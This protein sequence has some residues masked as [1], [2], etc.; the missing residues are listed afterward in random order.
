MRLTLAFAGVL[1]VMLTALGAYLVLRLRADLTADV[2]RSLSAR[3]GQVAAAYQT[4]RNPGEFA[5]ISASALA[6]LPS[7][8][9]AAQLL[10]T[11]GDILDTSDDPIATHHLLGAGDLR[12]VLAHG[13]LRSTVRVGMP[14]RLLA[15]PVTV[16]GQ[17][18]VLVLATSLAGIE[19]ATHR[20][21]VLLLTGGPLALLLASGTGWWLA[22]AALHPVA[23]MTAKARRITVDRLDERVAP[24]K[25]DDEL[26]RL[27]DTFNAM[28]DRLQEGVQIQHRLVADASHEL[29]TPLAVMRAELDVALTADGLPPDAVEVVSST[30]EEVD[31]MARLVGNLLALARIDQGRLDL[32]P[33]PV[34]LLDEADAVALRQGSLG[35][36][37]GL[38]IEVRGDRQVVIGDRERLVQVLTN[39]VD[40]GVKYT[41][42]GGVTIEVWAST[43][44][45]EAGITVS[46]TGPGVPAEE[47]THLFSRFY[48]VDPARTGPGG[49][50]LGL[51]IADEIIRAHGGRI[52]ADSTPGVGSRFSFALPTRA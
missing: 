43:D 21:V 20:V 29:R 27:A 1:A 47:L 16:S 15:E 44:R 5:E 18:R 48:R 35:A 13:A 42:K 41:E 37:K 45:M 28:L 33:R 46:D 24:P 7:G 51:A 12:T 49:S 10:S 9:S 36:A 17:R 2:D 23:S 32:L 31:R 52:W 26:G 8:A 40:N 38:T 19:T 22:G 25:V 14:I 11:T 3:A 39:L 50:G 4:D 34:D 6:G 30:S